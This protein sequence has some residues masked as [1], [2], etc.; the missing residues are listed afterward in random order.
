MIPTPSVASTS[1]SSVTTPT[2]AHRPALTVSCDAILFF[3][4]V[5]V[6]GV[7]LGISMLGDVRLLIYGV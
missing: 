5:D 2:A 6:D 4:L 7:R 3:F 1:T